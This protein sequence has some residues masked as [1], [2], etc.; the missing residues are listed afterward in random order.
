MPVVALRPPVAAV[1]VVRP[2]GAALGRAPTA[3]VPPTVDAP[4][5]VVDVPESDPTGPGACHGAGRPARAP[6]AGLA[7]ARAGR[8]SRRIAGTPPSGHSIRAGLPAERRV[9][10]A[11]GLGST[12]RP[13]DLA[14]PIPGRVG[15]GVRGAP[16][17]RVAGRTVRWGV[18]LAVGP[19]GVRWAAPDVLR[20]APTV[21]RRPVS[22]PTAGRAGAHHGG[23]GAAVVAVLGVVR[24]K[25]V[26]AQPKSVRTTAGAAAH[27][28]AWV[29]W[30]APWVARPGREAARAGPVAVEAAA[31]PAVGRVVPVAR[32]VARRWVS[33]ERASFA[34]LPKA[35]RPA[36]A[37]VARAEVRVV[38][39]ARVARAEV[40]VARVA[41]AGARVA[42]AEV[43]RRPAVAR[44]WVSGERAS[45][46]ALP[47]ARRPAVARV[48]PAAARV[49]TVGVQVVR[50]AEPAVVVRRWAAG[51]W[52]VWVALP[53]RVR[54]PRRRRPPVSQSRTAAARVGWAAAPVESV[55]ARVVVRR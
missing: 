32:S 15:S 45:F 8:G 21:V 47:K 22:G 40:R 18:A 51:A 43:P 16:A 7:R 27:R 29:V 33:G 52:A 42:S 44:R 12:G 13:R 11:L 38:R 23:S 48:A 5:L 14:R 37:R 50:A 46:A 54:S 26:A 30:V 36:V 49:G 17:A 6:P 34:A 41:R 3:V 10:R 39:V 25:P 2:P 28:W 9:R 35:R 4:A 24:A 31:A 55:A 19:A 53:Q 1:A 20:V